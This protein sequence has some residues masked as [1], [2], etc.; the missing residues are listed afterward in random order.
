MASDNQMTLIISS[1]REMR[2]PPW[3]KFLRPV[4]NISPED[5]AA[6]QIPKRCSVSLSMYVGEKMLQQ[7]NP[8]AQ[9]DLS[10]SG[11]QTS[12]SAHRTVSEY[13][14][15]FHAAKRAVS[16]QQLIYELDNVCRAKGI[17]PRF[18]HM[19]QDP[20]I[21]YGDNDVPTAIG[22]ERRTFA[23]IKALVAQIPCN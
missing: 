12:A 23:E 2:K 5:K 9:S 15:L 8:M 14:A 22:R 7:M 21:L 19:I 3:M 18:E 20:L 4:L 10:R 13:M 17:P 6:E 16:T 11:T 1:S